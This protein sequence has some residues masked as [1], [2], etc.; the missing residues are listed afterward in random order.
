[1]NEEKPSVFASG[2]LIFRRQG[3]QLQFLLM[4]HP[5]RWDLPKGHLDPNESIPQAAIRELY[6]ETGIPWMLFG[7]TP[8]SRSFIATSSPIANATVRRMEAKKSSKN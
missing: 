7:P 3:T 4:K 5:D 2:Y 1:M 8:S 6:E